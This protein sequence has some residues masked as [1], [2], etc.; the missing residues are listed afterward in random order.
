MADAVQVYLD[1]V[2]EIKATLKGSILLI[3]HQFDLSRIHD[4]MFGTCDAVIIQPFGR[5]V[6]IDYKHGAG[7][8]V[9]VEENPQA[10][11]YGL[12]ALAHPK[13][14]GAEEVE[15]IIVQPRAQGAPVRRWLT[16]VEH[17]EAFSN[18]L[19]DK[20]REATGPEA[21]FVPGDHCKWCPYAP[22]CGAIRAEATAVARVPDPAF[23]PVS[24]P[25]APSSLTPEQLGKVLFWSDTIETWLGSVRDYVKD[26]LRQGQTVPGYKL[27]QGRATRKWTDEKLVVDTLPASV[28]Y[29]HKLRSPAQA[30]K[31][32]KAIG[33]DPKQILPLISETRGVSL[34]PAEDPRPALNTNPGFTPISASAGSSL[35]TPP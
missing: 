25:P 26:L 6:V 29:E 13:A 17:L 10:M 23:Q 34:A 7:K 15:L 28:I 5:V 22:H 3:E 35:R 19:G 1:T 21:K 18:L 24:T 11:F 31:A 27:V 20:A 9:E 33:A 32:L 12:G 4:G 30:E 14:V 2:R 16:T 8:F